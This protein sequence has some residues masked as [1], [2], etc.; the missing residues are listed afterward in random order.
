[1]NLTLQPMDVKAPSRTIRT[2]GKG[3]F[4]AIELTPG[5]YQVSVNGTKL[6]QTV[7]VSAGQVSRVTLGS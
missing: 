7:N 6:Q 5:T 2:D 4:G 1:V 3:W